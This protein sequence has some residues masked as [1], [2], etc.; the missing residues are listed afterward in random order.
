MDY[1]FLKIRGAINDA[2]TLPDR[3]RP[4]PNRDAL[5]GLTSRT[6]PEHILELIP[7]SVARENCVVPLALDGDTLTVAAVNADDVAT[8]DKLTFIINKSIRMLPAPADDIVAALN[9]YYRQ[10]ETEAVDSMITEF[11]DTAIDLT[12]ANQPAIADLAS[13]IGEPMHT[14]KKGMRGLAED[15]EG[16]YDLHEPFDPG[17]GM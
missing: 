17:D 4:P 7:E 16:S 8:K 1:Q 3:L 2:P 15:A 10:C 5:A 14:F 12:K 9:H 11:Y 6:I 13:R